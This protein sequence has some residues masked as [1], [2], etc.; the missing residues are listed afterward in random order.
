MIEMR[1]KEGL[2]YSNDIPK[3]AKIAHVVFFL[4][5]CLL[6][7]VA[8]G[9]G[10]FLIL[11]PY[12]PGGIICFA[13][14]LLL[15]WLTSIIYKSNKMYT[16]IVMKCELR[17]DGYFT[18]VRNVKTGEEWENFVAF[19][20]MQEVLIARTTRYMSRG[21]NSPGYHI[22]GAK[23]IMKWINKQGHHKYSLFGVENADKLN[24]WVQRFK[25]KDIP[26][27]SSGANVTGLQLEDY[28]RAYE[29][30]PKLPYDQDKS[31][32][33]IGTAHYRNLK[34]WLSSEMKEKKKERQ[35]KNDRRVFYPILL[36]LFIFNFIVTVNWMPSWELADGMFGIESPSFLVASINFMLL[37]FV[38]TYWRE[39]VKWYRSVR[40]VGLI[41]LAQLIGWVCL[42][43]FQT[44]PAGM[45]DAVIVDGLTLALFN[46]FFFILFRALKK[47]LVK[48]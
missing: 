17:E 35:L 18:F 29:E 23:I 1:E 30:L 43:L 12:W 7:V 47:I 33:I 5:F 28:E 45:L 21:S 39:K 37:F 25:Q 9:F 22:I 41:L 6:G 4:F 2:K 26:V 48:G 44:V 46:G 34:Q 16:D 31:S 11:G 8:F 15:A 32:P 36:A 10:V 24:E 42:W 19:E 38:G 14:A 40:D 20:Q 27:F 13:C 3:W